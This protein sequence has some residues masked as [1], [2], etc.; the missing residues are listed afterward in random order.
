MFDLIDVARDVLDEQ[1][2]KFARII[3]TSYDST[4]ELAGFIFKRPSDALDI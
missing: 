4:I 2:E 1:V 3:R